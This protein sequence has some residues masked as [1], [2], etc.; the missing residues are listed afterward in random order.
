MAALVRFPKLGANVVEGAV[1]AWRRRE[2]DSV[3]KGDPL[4]EIVTS[5]ATFDVESPADGVLRRILAPEKSNLP[6]GYVLALVGEPG[7]ELPDVD[8]ENGRLL[9]AFRAEAL[10]RRSGEAEPGA[11]AS[12]KKVR[13]TPGARRLAIELGIDLGEISLPSGSGVIREE[14]VRRSGKS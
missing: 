2:G 14:D 1:S 10:Q 6:V 7:E 12:R 13:A 4:V 11:T 8:G 5:K 3:R 9:A